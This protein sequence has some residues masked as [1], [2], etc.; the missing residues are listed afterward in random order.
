MNK[1]DKQNLHENMNS[2]ISTSIVIRDQLLDES[3]PLSD[4]NAKLKVFQAAI[5]ANKSIVSATIT[6]LN[7]DKLSDSLG[8]L[9]E[10]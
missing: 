3:V 9:N 8:N 7:I 5:N 4:R 10:N 2:V 1:Q 6:Q